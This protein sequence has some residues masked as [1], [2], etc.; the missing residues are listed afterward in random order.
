MK[1]SIGLLLA[2]CVASV[3]GA[4]TITYQYDARGRLMLVDT[5]GSALSTV[6]TYG[7]DR[8]D[9]RTA[10]TSTDRTGGIVPIY[11]FNNGKHF[12]TPI[13]SEGINA[14]FTSEGMAFKTYA[15][16]AGGMHALYRCY[17]GSGDHFVSSASNCEGQTVIWSIGYVFGTAGSGR[18]ALYRFSGGGEHL[19]TTNYSEGT[20]AGYSYDGVLG[21]VPN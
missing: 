2:L 9:N 13:F 10:V 8:A 18:T 14:G 17:A 3:A 20:A 4:E 15:S 21:Y 5:T 12:Y 7:H 19:V 16:S 1:R 11:R 6:A